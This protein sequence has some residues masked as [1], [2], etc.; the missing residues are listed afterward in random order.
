[1]GALMFFFFDSWY[2][3]I[4]WIFSY[5]FLELNNCV[6]ISELDKQFR[7]ITLIQRVF[8]LCEKAE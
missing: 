3:V 6:Q 8:L 5:L 1:M 4:Q 2:E 7:L